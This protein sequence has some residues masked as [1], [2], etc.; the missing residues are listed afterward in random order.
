ME[1]LAK[2]LLLKGDVSAHL[3]LLCT[4]I[5]SASLIIRISALLT[6]NLEVGEAKFSFSTM[7]QNYLA[8]GN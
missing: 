1:S 7:S 4:E 6:K 3:V 5:P 8:R 2:G